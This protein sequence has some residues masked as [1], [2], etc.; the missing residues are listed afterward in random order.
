ML[1]SFKQAELKKKRSS[2]KI[3]IKTT[4]EREADSG[5]DKLCRLSPSSQPGAT[6]GVGAVP[7]GEETMLRSVVAPAEL[8]SLC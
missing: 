2:G 8:T 1:E 5:K 7:A 6:Q 3:K 4:S